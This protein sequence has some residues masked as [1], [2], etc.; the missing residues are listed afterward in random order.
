MWLKNCRGKNRRLDGRTH[1]S[2][3]SLLL[4]DHRRPLIDAD[5]DTVSNLDERNTAVHAVL[6]SVEGHCPF[7]RARACP[8]PLIANVN[9]SYLVILVS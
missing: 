6:L 4:K 5:L 3:R 2:A 9:F 7:N 8:L 1:H